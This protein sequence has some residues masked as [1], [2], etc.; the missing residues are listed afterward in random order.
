M[1]Q[2]RYFL[3]VSR[4]LN[5]TRAAKECHVAQPSLTRAIKLLETE[6][7]A[8]LFRRE[9]SLSHLT[10]F[11]QRM[12]P[13]LRQC[14]ESALA[15]KTLAAAIRTG[16]ASSLTL[17]L[18]HTVPMTLLVP[19]LTEVLRAFPGLELTFF[20]GTAAEVVEQLKQGKAVL[21]VAGPLAET[22]ERL[23]AWPLFSE[24]FRV[25]VGASHRLSGRNQIAIQDLR[26]ERVLAR[27]YCELAGAVDEF[28]RGRDILQAGG[29]G[30]A[31]ESDLIALVA[32]GIGLGIAPRSTPCPPELRALDAE[33][34]E[35]SRT[36]FL[37]AVAGR[38]RS[39]PTTA[40]IKLLRARDWSATAA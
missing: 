23:D 31:S 34:L 4:T 15:A 36:V 14:Y 2:V 22:W 24:P 26:A 32:A 39:T 12:L 8:D 5:F 28:A 20:R 18:S 25:L 11:G 1:H 29:H 13:L 6:L 7:G 17:A 40:L 37:Y 9:R 21:A 35:L 27:P 16:A 33:G 38:A 10:E 19:A 3:A 30:V